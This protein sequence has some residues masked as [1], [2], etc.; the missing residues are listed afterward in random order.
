MNIIVPAVISGIA[1]ALLLVLIFAKLPFISGVAKKYMI[2]T[3]AVY[4][5][6]TLLLLILCIRMTQLPF[7]FVVISEISILSV[8]VITM[9]S[10]MVITRNISKIL[11]EVEQGK[12]KAVDDDEQSKEDN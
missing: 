1:A 11:A 9:I 10:I 7:V 6:G 12:I 5:S 2:A 8:F 4:L 3:A